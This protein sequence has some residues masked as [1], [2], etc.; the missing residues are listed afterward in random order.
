MPLIR[1]NKTGHKVKKKIN[2][3]LLLHANML[4][5]YVNIVYFCLSHKNLYVMW[6]IKRMLCVA[7]QSVVLR[8][9]AMTSPG[10]LLEMQ[11]LRPYH[12]ASKSGS[13]F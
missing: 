12:R 5:L 10:S 8:P 2:K 3:I 13:A 1:S 6:L 7:I 9:V 4:Y 11:N